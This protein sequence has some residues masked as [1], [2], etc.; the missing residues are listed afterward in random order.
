VDGL[1]LEPDDDDGWRQE[2]DR[3]Q[4]WRDSIEWSIRDLPPV[5]VYGSLSVP[6]WHRREN[7]PRVTFGWY[8]DHE[9]AVTV[10]ADP[11]FL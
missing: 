8:S 2:L 7:H 5:P 9:W 1:F 6:G 4:A 10:P 3:W 11:E